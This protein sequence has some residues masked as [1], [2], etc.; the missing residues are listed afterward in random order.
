MNRWALAAATAAGLF[1]A[2]EA[3]VRI[4]RLVDPLCVTMP[5]DTYMRYRGKPHAREFNGFRLNSRGYKD[6]EF[7]PSKKPGVFRIIGLGDSYTYGAVPYRYGYMTLLEDGLRAA[8]CGCEVLN[9]GVPA[10]GPVDYLSLFVNEG[11]SLGPDMVLINLYLG[12]DFYHGGTRFRLYSWSVAATWINSLIA[13][14]W[15]PEGRSFGSGV[16]RDDEMLQ[17]EG[18]YIRHL[19]RIESGPFLRDNREFRND[20]SSS[21]RYLKEIKKICD[22]KG[23]GFAVVVCPAEL[24]VYPQLQNK[25]VREMHLRKDNF[26][27]SLPNRML[28][29]EFERLGVDYLDL[30]EPL[31]RVYAVRGRSFNKPNDPH[32][33]IYGNRVAARLVG[34]W[35]SARIT[36]CKKERAFRTGNPR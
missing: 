13:N 6:V 23:I 22:L 31:V 9:L 5:D 18:S 2:L 33:N 20:F 17:S 14:R 36:A 26:D 3:G 11:L 12:D 19:V 1:I 28:G 7:S 4:C 27:F 30:L 8:G 25:V 21:L 34:P 15:P 32:W 10:A 29:R 24:Q 16:Y 35:F